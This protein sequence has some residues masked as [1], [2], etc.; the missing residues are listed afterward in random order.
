[1]PHRWRS[2]GEFAPYN[3]ATH[4]PVPLAA[5]FRLGAYEVVSQLG[6]GGMGEVYRATDTVLKRQVALKLLPLD[7]AGD[8]DRVARFQR[9][10]EVLA[11]LNHPNIAHLYGIEKSDGTLALV[12][13]LVEG[14]TLADRIAGGPLP[15]EETLQAARQIADALE[16]AHEQGIIH[17]D[18]KPANIKLRPDGTIKVLDF[19]LA[20]ATEQGSGIRDQG[21][22]NASISPTITSPAVVPF[23]YRAGQ[24]DQGGGLTGVG[25]ILGTAAYMSPEQARGKTVD[26]RADIWAFGVIIYEMLSGQRAFHGEEM[27]DVLASV[28]RQDVDWRLLPAGTSPRLRRLL[29]RCLERDP[30]MRLRDIGEARVEIDKALSGTAEDTVAL[31]PPVAVR[32]RFAAAGWIAAAA[33]ALAAAALGWRLVSVPPPADPSTVRFTV[34]LPGKSGRT[35]GYTEVSPDGRFV[36]LTG[37]DANGRNQLWLRPLGAAEAHPLPGTVGATDPCW[38]PDGRYVAFV[39]NRQISKIRI[40]TERVETVAEVESGGINGLAWAPNG[41]ILFALNLGG[42]LRV[43]AAG[44]A[45]EPFTTLDVARKETRHYYPDFLPDGRHVLFV[46]TSPL[47]E[48]AGVWV[49]ALDNPLDR[50]RVLPD[51]SRARFSQGHLIFSRRGSLMAQP[52]DLAS[53]TVT[54]EASALGETLRSGAGITGFADFSTSDS[55]VLAIGASEPVMRMSTTDR[56]GHALATFGSPSLRYGFVRLSPDQRLVASD[57]IGQ[58]GYQVL[59]FDPERSMTT[60]LTAGQATGNFPVWSPDGDRI[61]FGSNRNGVYDIFIKSS[62]GSSSDE[63]LLANGNNKFLMDWSRDGR[64]IIYGEDQRPQRKE[65][66]WTL[67][68]TGERKPSLYLEEEADL[69]DGRFSPDGRFVAYTAIQ[70]TGVQVF[71]R[72]FPDPSVKLQVSVDGGSRPEWRADGRELFYIGADS[73]LMAVEVTPGPQPRLGAPSPLF[74]TGLYSNIF[75]FDVYRDGRRFVMPSNERSDQSVTIILNWLGLLKS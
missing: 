13:E 63:I 18:L 21:S 55:G 38:S 28:L 19:G 58:Q 7:V 41:M 10:A 34:P 42:L 48:V 66:L 67:P 11:A 39:A 4:K 70:P 12:M 69:R 59:V 30:R 37:E 57:T 64:F 17:R 2:D 16:A 5:G 25:V 54:G 23:G 49:A 46:V 6:A 35:L 3:A 50:H 8:P 62:S 14:P 51:L 75:T 36:T 9:E 1:L 33:M 74:R 56:S 52:F 24:P 47:P 27:S 71:I 31:P 40:D 61:A 45:A 73:D 22:G 29:A 53:L 43:P 65:R 44:G 72:S 60:A 68:M 32:G 20:K 15:I 26:K